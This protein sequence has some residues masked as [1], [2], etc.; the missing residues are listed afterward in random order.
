MKGEFR[1]GQGIDFHPFAEG[2]KLFLG[3]IEIPGARGLQGHSDADAL[4]HAIVDALLGALSLGDIGQ[5]FPDTDPKWKGKSSLYFVEHA[6]K[7][8]RDRGWKIANIDSTVVTEEPML[9]PHIEPMRK[10]LAE[11]L[12]LEVDQVSIKAT[13]PEKL[14]ALG[15]KEGL[16]ALASTLLV[17]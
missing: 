1:I 16:V 3:G 5:H 7:L 10:K 8:I 4:S 11:S 2:R 15:R 9:K 17:R 14:G 13:R 12:G 6:A